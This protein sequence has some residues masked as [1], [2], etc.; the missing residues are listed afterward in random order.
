MGAHRGEAG[1]GTFRDLLDEYRHEHT[2]PWVLLERSLDR[3]R[4]ASDDPQLFNFGFSNPENDKI[5][6]ATHRQYSFSTV[7]R[8]R[9]TGASYPIGS[10]S[11]G[12]TI[13]MSLCMATFNQTMGQRRPELLLFDELDAVLHPSMIAALIAGL[14]HEFV[15]NG[16]QVIMA[17]HSIT[18]VSALEDGE[19]YRIVRDRGELHVQPV[20][21]TEAVLELSEGVATID[22]GLRIVASKRSAPITILTEGHNALHLRKWASLFFPEQV[23]VF[24]D[25]PS[26]TGKDQ[27]LTYGRFLSKVVANTHFLIVWDC[28][29]KGNAKRLADELVGRVAVT[30]FALGERGNRIARAGIE[31]KYPEDVL[32][33]FSKIVLDG[34]TRAE[35]SCQF[36]GGK[37]TEF[38]RYIFQSGTRQHFV[39]FDDLHNTVTEILQENRV[40]MAKQ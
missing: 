1:R 24:D 2:P 6:F 35:T 32:Q 28:D 19:I 20:A 25:L 30:A 31:N 36:D 33:P 8:N 13:L 38:A 18:T 34:A 22:K 29:A 26:R 12:E 40:N 15:D 14:K 23:E 9:A 3:L 11:S 17:T 37:K 16:T 27:L 39:H 21:K 7:F 10:L 4:E 5:S